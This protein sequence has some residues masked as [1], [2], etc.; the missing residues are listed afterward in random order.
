MQKISRIYLGNCGY[1]M[2]WY[3]GLLFDLTDPET[4]QPTDTII[5]LE[6]GGGK[7]SLL[8][9]IF[10]CFDTSQDRFLKHL[11]SKNNHFSQYFSQDGL[12]G[13]ILVEW[14]MPTRTAGGMPYR[15]VVGQVVSIKAGNDVP[16]SDRMFF[17]FEAA[18]GLTLESVP[19]PKLGTAPA[20]SLAE[21][22]RWVH[23]EQKRHPDVYVTRKQADWQRHL[24]E[25][26]LI[27]LEMLQMQVNFS[28]QEGGFDTGFLNFSSETAF[29]QKF[30]HLTLDAQ[31]AAAV[32]DAVAAACDKL[33]RK[34][35][36]QSK[37]AE[38]TRFQVVL[39][40]FEEAANSYRLAMV[41]QMGVLING[42]RLALALDERATMRR[43]KQQR[44]LTYERDQRAIAATAASDVLSYGRQAASM[45][46]LLHVRTVRAAQEHVAQAALSLTAVQDEIKHVKAAR[47]LAEVAAE[48][49]RLQALEAQAALATEG[50]QPFRDQLE[51]EG[52]LLRTVLFQ[53]E[54]ALRE[55][56]RNLENESKNRDA[57]VADHRTALAED[58]KRRHN[59]INEQAQLTQQENAWARERER[60]VSS[61]LL[62][63][64][65]EVT[66]VA[67]T[68]WSGTE[69]QMR[70]EEAAHKIE[71]GQQE[72][73]ELH[74]HSEEVR[75]GSDAG[76]F[77]SDI[78][79]ATDFIGEGTAE[80]E[81]LS[82][83]PAILQAIESDTAAPDS[84]ALPPVLERVVAASALEVSL[85]DVRLAEL[86]ATMQ[87]IHETGVAGNSPDVALV[88]RQ[89]REA[90]VR[91][92]RPFNEYLADALPN[93]ER[94]RAL[95]L[96]DP[97][98]F[99][100][101]SVA[102]SEMDKARAI[103]WH[104][105]M[106]VRPVVVSPLA[107]EVAAAAPTH[108]VVPAGSDAA[109]N[110]AAADALAS[111]LAETIRLEERRRAEYYQRQTDALAALQSLKAYI[112]R[113]GE[114]KLTA[115]SIRRNELQG[116]LRFTL[117]RKDEARE[118]AVAASTAAKASRDAAID[119]D[120][121]AREARSHQQVLQHFIDEYEAN[122][123]TRVKR[124]AELE[125]MLE[126]FEARRL[127]TEDE[128]QRLE[129]I[130][131][132]QSK[133]AIKTEGMA[134]NLANERSNIE[135][136]D[137]TLPAEEHLKS[138][139][140]ELGAL[141][142]TYSDA[143]TVYK[144][145]AQDQLGVLEV[146]M[147]A[148]RKRRDEKKQEFTRDYPGITR[149]H[150]APFEG[151]D[152]SAILPGLE[153]K[154]SLADKEHLDAVSTKGAVERTS[155]D[156]H[157]RNRDVPAATPDIEALDAAALDAKKEDALRL[158]DEAGVRQK[159]ASDEAN[160]ARDTAKHLEEAAGQDG[161]LAKVLKSTMK[162]EDNPNPEL[163]AL[164]IANLTGQPPVPL[165]QLH[166][167]MLE[168]EASD[169][170]TRAIKN[171]G[172]KSSVCER[173]QEGARTAFD[174]VKKAA[175]EPELQKV[176]PELATAMLA[177]EFT[178]ACSDAA[179]LL[180]G[181]EDRIHTT[182]D[183][184]D[185]MQAD[186][187][188]CVEEMLALSRMALGLLNSAVDKRVPA[189]APYV[190][191]KAVLKMRANF[192]TINIESRR[193]ALTHYLDSLI[194]AN[195]PPAKGSDLV[196]EAVLRMYGGR[197]LGLQVL[198][199]VIDES[200]QYMP[201]EK[202]SNSGGE[203]V[204]MALFLY[205]VITQLRA[206]TQAKLHKVAGGP[207]ILD[208]PFAKATSPTMWK[209][210]RLLA[211]SMGVQLV[212]ATAIQDYNALAEFSAFVR[213]RRAGQ[214]SKTGR[215][216]LESVRYR[217]NDEAA[218]AWLAAPGTTEVA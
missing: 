74:W 108:L 4:C 55:T 143:L 62:A 13:F 186:F 166:E 1:S 106:P 160:R 91:S 162:L 215:W 130:T 14:E 7:T 30:F 18:N 205:V 208:N 40:S 164:Q 217:L 90:G 189:A 199:M 8:S 37:L 175:A 31:R 159:N 54:Q 181:L 111:T 76:R 126:D 184:L 93:A 100:G 61:G 155:E 73:Q 140:R 10:S 122:R 165:E 147:Q 33:R 46:S 78:K 57:T 63:A 44:E 69:Q 211:Q 125:A 104:D 182:Q 38:L 105:Q 36:Y 144:A 101:V 138:N 120:R 170:I 6:N 196:A 142:G 187:D 204:V 180:E 32:R 188:A 191:G 95:V 213:L 59:S 47:L 81:R 183:N 102:Q 66:Q 80:H 193:Q 87:A 42:A 218:N 161:R 56:Q 178:A 115:A 98:R 168:E 195:V 52:A 216:H 163:L 177:N 112:Q 41:G 16:E 39:R 135:F 123:E 50:L 200:Q 2:A 70:R 53:H 169:Q 151:K 83:L 107:L 20:T 65:N 127:A 176:E 92:A 60:M 75:L 17:S 174:A 206:E 154:R 23:D 153:T 137:K 35:H 113:F 3:D 19:A 197:P 117:E 94:A 43:D 82:Q 12:P 68:R 11:Q 99:Q 190:A 85:S 124:L 149:T 139:P 192:A 146:Q 121:L 203:G 71:Q 27:D 167:L 86:R 88:V 214:N 179:R 21:F 49:E 119:R 51:M 148:V 29:L 158:S 9:L 157:K 110:R 152:H 64:A 209:A 129:N 116:Q 77:E 118:K 136:Y 156:W 48:D 132:E 34:P 79:S 173:S 128:I 134:N 150:V 131:R 103:D 212:F 28:V 15:L 26:R 133:V 24:R 198:R 97:A 210:Q 114:G 25:E 22:S 89:L 171:Y 58:E 185:K 172:E 202:I 84:P 145:K 96:S 72:Q 67:L 141:R 194:Q 5:N 45:I 109:Y 207:L 201:V